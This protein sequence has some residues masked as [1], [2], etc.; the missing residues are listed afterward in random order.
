MPT[1]ESLEPFLGSS[2]PAIAM[3]PL[4]V[5][6]KVLRSFS[7]PPCPPLDAQLLAP[8]A[9]LRFYALSKQAAERF[10]LKLLDMWQWWYFLL[11]SFSGIIP[12]FFTNF[13]SGLLTAFTLDR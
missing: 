5:V 2:L 12:N 1:G 7:S 9:A 6:R 3:P 4:T 13:T 11:K 10:G 8:Q